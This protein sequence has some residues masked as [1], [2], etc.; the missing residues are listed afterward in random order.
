M[1][2]IGSFICPL[3]QRGPLEGPAG[4]DD[5]G[6]GDV[7]RL[8]HDDGRTAATREHLLDPVRVK[9]PGIHEIRPVAEEVGTKYITAYIILVMWRAGDDHYL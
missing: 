5:R 6:C 9:G 7:G 8:D 3:G 1:N 2:V 4:R